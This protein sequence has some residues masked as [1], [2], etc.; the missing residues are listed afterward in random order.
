MPEYY[1]VIVATAIFLLTYAVIISEKIHRTVVAFAGAALVVVIGMAEKR[2]A[3][4]SF[5]GFMKVAFPLM[6]MSV[7]LSMAYL[8]FW[9]V[10]HTLTL[11]S[12][13][14]ERY[15]PGYR[16]HRPGGPPP[17]AGFAGSRP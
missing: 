17:V 13:G 11:Y 14:G 5:A 1:Q 12:P 2:G 9:Y 6:L 8:V 10:F 16:S 3:P 4:I 15:D 7:V